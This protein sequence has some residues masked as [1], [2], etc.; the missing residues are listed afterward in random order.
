M[1]LFAAC[2]HRPQPTA[3][4]GYTC[5]IR[6]A[7]RQRLNPHQRLP[8]GPVLLQQPDPR[9]RDGLRQR[10][11]Q[12]QPV[13]RGGEVLG[14]QLAAGPQRLERKA[15]H[16]QHLIQAFACAVG[17][18]GSNRQAH[19]GGML[20]EKHRGHARHAPLGG[21]NAMRVLQ[22]CSLRSGHPTLTLLA[23]LL[24]LAQ[25]LAPHRLVAGPFGPGATDGRLQR[26][27][28][29]GGHLQLPKFL[30]AVG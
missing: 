9:G 19:V 8:G 5:A 25:R 28:R 3:S 27:E 30:H 13:G 11:A 7:Q 21:N 17:V 2:C 14:G 12:V 20:V 24:G 15:A 23:V 22:T 4:R 6:A 10:R 1:A 18:W 26:V 16:P 29:L